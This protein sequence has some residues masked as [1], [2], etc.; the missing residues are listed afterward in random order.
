MWVSLLFLEFK[1]WV[2]KIRFRAE[3]STTNWTWPC[4][5]PC[6]SKHSSGFMLEYCSFPKVLIPNYNLL[7]QSVK[8]QNKKSFV[9]LVYFISS[10]SRKLGLWFQP[11]L[12]WLCCSSDSSSGLW[13]A[14]HPWIYARQERLC[15]F[16]LCLNCT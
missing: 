4:R 1:G 13:T 15:R 9:L 5:W 10:H 3:I 7:A 12:S 16:S 6:P 11:G 14:A 2:W 8:G